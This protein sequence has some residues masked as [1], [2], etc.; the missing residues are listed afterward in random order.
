[1]EANARRVESVVFKPINDVDVSVELTGREEK[2]LVSTK[3]VKRR[4]NPN[5][6]IDYNPN[7]IG[8]FEQP[9]SIKNSE[10]DGTV[11][12]ENPNHGVIEEAQPGDHLPSSNQQ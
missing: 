8:D 1:M 2:R 4:K 5:S 10:I 6:D 11:L 7:S 3:V 12:Q 9:L